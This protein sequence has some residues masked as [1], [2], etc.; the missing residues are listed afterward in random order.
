MAAGVGLLAYCIAKSVQNSSN[1][2]SFPIDPVTLPGEIPLQPSEISNKRIAAG[3]LAIVMG[4][5]GVHKFYLGFTGT[6][7]IM[8]LVTVLSIFILSPVTGIIGLIE[9]IIYLAKSDRE[10]YRDYI[11]RKRAWF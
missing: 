10:F 9:G 7:L 8:L 6:G 1:A 5:L 4:S 2:S 3:I 11:V